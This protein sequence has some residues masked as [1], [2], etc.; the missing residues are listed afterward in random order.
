MEKK[1]HFTYKTINTVN[2]KYYYGVHSTDNLNDNYKGTGKA[3]KSA[4]KKYGK[5]SFIVEIIEF[6]DS[7]FIASE[8]EKHLITNADLNNPMCYNLNPGGDNCSGGHS[9]STKLKISAKSSGKNNGMFGKKHSQTTRNKLAGFKNRRHTIETKKL[10]SEARIGIKHSEE[11]K[12]KIG[13]A[14]KGKTGSVFSHSEEAKNKI[15]L[16]HK[17]EKSYRYDFR[18]IEGTNIKTGEICIFK[19]KSEAAKIVNG[20]SSNIGK[21]CDGIYSKS[22]GYYWKYV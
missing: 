18:N 11:T 2:S 3:L 17:G 22:S 19:S 6:Y 4:F 5:N 1:Y 12:R 9:E 20:T 15:S 7:R 14:H 21:A 13:L 16:A 8:A 10:L